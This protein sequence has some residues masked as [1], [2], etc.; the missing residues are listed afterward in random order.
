MFC[1]VPAPRSNQMMHTTSELVNHR[2]STVATFLFSIFASFNSIILDASFIIV[3]TFSRR[4]ARH[5]LCVGK[6]LG[7]PLETKLHS[8]HL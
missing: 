6:V 7:S 8:I 5:V 3:H 4:S 1:L 2:L